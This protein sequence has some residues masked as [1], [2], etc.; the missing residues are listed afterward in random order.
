MAGVKGKSGGSRRGAGRKPDTAAEVEKKDAA[1][2]DIL[3][4]MMNDPA[5]S[6]SLRIAAAKAAAP[7][8]HKKLAD[9]GK[10]QERITAAAGAGAGKFAPS[11]PPKLKIVNG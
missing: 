9:A 4:A 10:K 5:V 6:A 11:A 8:R 2:L 1:P 7:Y 3:E